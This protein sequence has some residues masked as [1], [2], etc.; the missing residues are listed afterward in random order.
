MPGSHLTPF[1]RGQIQAYVK[2]KPAFS[3]RLRLQSYTDKW[4]RTMSPAFTISAP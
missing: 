1:E 3:Y 2:H 4:I